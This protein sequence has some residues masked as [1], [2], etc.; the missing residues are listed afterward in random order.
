M[1][2]V[3][4]C[5]PVSVKGMFFVNSMEE[6]VFESVFR[7]KALPKAKDMPVNVWVRLVGLKSK[8]QLAS[9]EARLDADDDSWKRNAL[10]MALDMN[11]RGMMFRKK[12]YPHDKPKLWKVEDCISKL[13]DFAHDVRRLMKVC[14]LDVSV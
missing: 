1:E 5:V 8:A 11:V 7:L 10:T 2:A 12:E 14:W 4:R 6:S 13:N 9:S 3:V